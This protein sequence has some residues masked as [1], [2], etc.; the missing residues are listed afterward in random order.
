M[1]IPVSEINNYLRT[2]IMLSP[3]LAK[4]FLSSYLRNQ[5]RNRVGLRYSCEVACLDLYCFCAMC[6]AMNRSRS[7]LIVQS[8][9]E[10][11]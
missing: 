2:Y 4:L 8:S 5:N 6:F 1:L 3:K 10:T 7:G 11:A 9:L